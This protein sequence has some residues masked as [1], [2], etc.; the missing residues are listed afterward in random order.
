MEISKNQFVVLLKPVVRFCMRHAVRLQDCLELLK[1]AYIEV[2][3]EELLRANEKLNTSRMSV[4]TG[5]HRKDVDRLLGEDRE[6]KLS[7]NIISRV[8]ALWQFDKRFLGQQRQPRLL[9]FEGKGNDF[10]KLVSLV[11]NDVN[12]S[13][14]LFELERSGTVER[15]ERGL[16]L[17]NKI[18]LSGSEEGLSLLAAD[19][20]D[21][22]LAVE[23]NIL[24]TPEI[25]NLHL[26]TEYDNIP[27]EDLPEI[28]DWFL[29]EGSAF[30][31]R[32]RAFLSRFDRDV[33]SPISRGT[34]ALPANT[35]RPSDRARVALGTFS[36]CEALNPQTSSKKKPPSKR[37]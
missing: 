37:T 21:L 22:F 5:V 20:S 35:T 11:S 1:A 30:H 27:P 3:R 29:R 7:S 36:F 31:E 19:Q 16:R 17:L 10:S 9:S 34:G 8:L 4:M 6:L 18:A 2:A 26:K 13:T 14:I 33:Q 15:T 12:P 25:P 23:E 28:R 32:A 24:T